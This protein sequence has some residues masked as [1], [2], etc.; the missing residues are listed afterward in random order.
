MLRWFAIS[1]I[2]TCMSHCAAFGSMNPFV[3]AKKLWGLL[4]A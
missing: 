3:P 4:V 1:H 2:T